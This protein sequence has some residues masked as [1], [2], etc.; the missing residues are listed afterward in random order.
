[1]FKGILINKD[2]EGY[3]TTLSDLDEDQIPAG[4]VRVNVEYSTLNYKDALAITGKAPIIRSFPLIPGIDFA[5]TVEHSDH[6][7]FAAGDRVVLNGWGVG[8]KH[9]VSSLYR[10]AGRVKLPL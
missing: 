1:M 9:P 7:D 4:E 6:P 8:E 5:G 10:E 2:D 3:R